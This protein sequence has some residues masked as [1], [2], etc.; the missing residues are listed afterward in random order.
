MPCRSSTPSIPGRRG[1]R[2]KRS[3]NNDGNSPAAPSTLSPTLVDAVFAEQTLPTSKRPT[4]L[5]R[6]AGP[7]EQQLA[8]PGNIFTCGNGPCRLERDGCELSRPGEMLPNP[9]PKLCHYQGNK[10]V[11]ASSI[12]LSEALS[13]ALSQN[14]RRGKLHKYA[15]R[16]ADMPCPF[17]GVDPYLEMQP[18]WSD[19]APAFLT[20]IRNDVAFSPFAAIRCARRRI[21]DADGTGSQSSPPS[22]RRK[23]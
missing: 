20:A 9:S 23:R 12:I 10:S 5:M 7:T 14:D 18:F 2:R 1:R 3:A 11:K 6:R 13:R 4:L 21:S 16:R 19:F 17:P 22:P 15:S 8:R